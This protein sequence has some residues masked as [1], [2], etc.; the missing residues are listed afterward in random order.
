MSKVLKL[1]LI[2][3]LL[4]S[5][6]ALVLA[7]MLFGQRDMLKGR[8][9]K[10]EKYAVEVAQSLRFEEIQREELKDLKGMDAPLS[11]LVGHSQNTYIELQDTKSDL[12]TTSDALAAKTEESN[13]TLDELA[14]VKNKISSFSEEVAQKDRELQDTRSQLMAIETEK[15]AIVADIE[16]WE[17][18]LIQSDELIEDLRAEVG[19][20][21]KV[22]EEQESIIGGNSQ[23]FEIEPG[24]MGRLLAVNADWNFVV[25]DIGSEAGL[26]SGAEMLVHRKDEFIGKVKIVSVEKNMA[27]ADILRSWQ[28]KPFETGDNVL[29][30][31]F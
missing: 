2:L 29:Y 15:S 28:A 7:S 8:I 6:V 31:V 12:E 30:A 13:E 20:L 22:I 27:I 21:E 24:T 9:L 25:L 10:Y 18:R 3:T 17:N 26:G 23:K 5:I 16:D 1:F 4:M 19:T 14:T 11:K